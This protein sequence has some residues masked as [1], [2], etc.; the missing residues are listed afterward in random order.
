[1]WWVEH[2]E[3]M[4]GKGEICKFLAIRP[5]PEILIEMLSE[6]YEK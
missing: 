6:R 4:G 5:E 1:M 2:V 3:R